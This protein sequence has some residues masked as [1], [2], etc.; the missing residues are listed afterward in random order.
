M[1]Y[2]KEQWRETFSSEDVKQTML[3]Q[4]RREMRRKPF[5]SYEAAIVQQVAKRK[6]SHGIDLSHLFEEG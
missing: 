2:L 4:A 1:S 3:R 5:L 6:A